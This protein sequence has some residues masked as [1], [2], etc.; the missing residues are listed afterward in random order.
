VSKA[1]NRNA[2]VILLLSCLSGCTEE[3]TT[4]VADRAGSD[5]L[6]IV[7]IN[8]PLADFARH[9]GGDA[10]RVTLPVPAG[11]DPAFWIPD[12]EDILTMQAA[13]LVL[14]NGAGYEPWLDQVSLPVGTAVDTSRYLAESLI[15]TDSVTH[16]HGPDGDHSHGASA[17]TI[18]LDPLL[19]L[20]QAKAIRDALQ[21]RRGDLS[22]VID[23]RFSELEVELLAL[24]QAWQKVADKLGD[25]P[26][27]FSH[28]VYQ[29]LQQRYQFN[30]SSLH[31]E[32]DE[33][34]A[35]VEW[36]A[37]ERVL[38]AHPAALMIW[39]AEPVPETVERLAGSGVR[40]VVVNP[41]ANLQGTDRFLEVQHMG[42]RAI[43][44]EDLQ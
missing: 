23:S 3:P 42:I 22:S 6:A 32:P 38:A 13:D 18:W 44:G 8:S 27:I 2:A 41:G 5:V 40:V 19:A 1:L 28:P 37:L 33:D 17:F 43:F 11:A 34:P 24:H 31:W 25:A 7:A 26:V 12:V 16:Q 30:G 15:Y 9:L 29:Y 14:L 21:S 10:V 36:Q 35:E 4:V 39:E 20:E